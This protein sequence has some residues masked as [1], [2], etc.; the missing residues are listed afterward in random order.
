MKR[1]NFIFYAIL[2]GFFSLLMSLIVNQGALL[3]D[4]KYIEHVE[5]GS[6]STFDEFQVSLMHSI[7]H[8]LSILLLQVLTILIAARIVGFIFNKIG[9]PTVIGEIVAG[10]ILGPSLLGMYFPEYL[11]FLF[12]LDSMKPLQLISQIGLILFMFVIGME[13][14]LSVLRNKAYDA[15]IISHASIIIPF[16]LGMGLAYFIYE[17]YAPDNIGFISFALFIGI[18]MSITAFP[19]LA[20]IVKERKLTKTKVG[21]I[22]I[23]C[24]A[25]DDVTAWFALAVVIAIVKAGSVASALYTI[26]MSLGYLL[27][28]IKVVRPILLKYTPSDKKTF[29][30]SL[31]SIYFIVL[32]VSASATEIIGIHALFGAFIAGLIIPENLNLRNSFVDK[33][34][35]VATILLLPLFFVCTGLRTQI[36]LISGVHLWLLTGAIIMVAIAGKFLGSAI[37]ARYIGQSW[38][39]SLMIGTLMNARGLVELVV[40]NIGYDL[41]VLS[42]LVFSMLVIM[43]LFTTFMT[44]PTLDL[45]NYFIPG[46]IPFKPVR[47]D[48]VE[49]YESV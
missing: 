22:V 16:A 27:F 6:G 37:T 14:D 36:S 13:L 5:S 41:G 46:R 23:T 2:V 25:A 28:M 19:V 45:I 39:N 31:I 47:K 18:A 20:R 48:E 26:A 49:T 17:E 9:Q 1:K 40:L 15:L 33:V 12:P 4:S 3:E 38:K 29:S 34:E 30:K 10:I 44:G 21:T 35:D 24:A 7:K 8:P 42:P 43:A 11:E 32:V